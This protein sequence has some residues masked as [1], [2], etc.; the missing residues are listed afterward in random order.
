MKDVVTF[1]MKQFWNHHYVAV[2]NEISI[3]NFEGMFLYRRKGG[4]GCRMA[5]GDLRRVI[6]LLSERWA[7]GGGE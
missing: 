7:C 4:A 2:F 1:N 5:T 3:L 6:A